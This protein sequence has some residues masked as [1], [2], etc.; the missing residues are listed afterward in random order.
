MLDKETKQNHPENPIAKQQL[1]CMRLKAGTQQGRVQLHSFVSN[2]SSAPGFQL[3]PPPLLN[4]V[5]EMQQGPV[6]VIKRGHRK[7]GGIIKE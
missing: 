6:I 4:I 7:Y 1:V 3:I 5:N 2:M